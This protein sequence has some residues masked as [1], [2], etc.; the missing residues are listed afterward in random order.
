[1]QTVGYERLTVGPI[2]SGEGN[3][4]FSSTRPSDELAQEIRFLAEKVRTLEA[5]LAA[6][7]TVDPPRARPVEP[8]LSPVFAEIE[9][10][11]G[12]DAVKSELKS[13]IS[14]LE[15]QKMRQERGHPRLPLSLHMVFMGPPGTG[16]TTVA[17]LIGKAFK[18]LGFLSSGHCVEVD[19]ADLVAGY[20]GQTAMKVDECVQ[21]ATGGVLF[22]DEAYSLKPAG[23]GSDFGQEAI[24][25]LLK[26]MEDK[27]EELVIIIAGYPDEMTRFLESNPGLRSRF[28]RTFNFDH[29]DPDTLLRLFQ[30]MCDRERYV[31]EG[32]GY[33]RLKT[34]FEEAY[35]RRSKSF[36]NGRYV[37]EAFERIVVAQSHRLAAMPSVGDADLIALT[38]DDVA[39]ALEN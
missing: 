20:V 29:Y 37:R 16:K 3:V 15:I 32:E 35:R 36:G 8:P 28:G 19:R 12:M 6:K 9:A 39:R 31:M 30:S 2:P 14:F 26:R 38:A 5:A 7:G 10:L 18:Q 24:D 13:L 25:T 17:R 11:V 34:L 22:I 23:S 33:K 4:V 27:R 1:R 21:R